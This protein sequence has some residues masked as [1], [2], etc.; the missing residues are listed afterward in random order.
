MKEY[1]GSSI[2]YLHGIFLK[3]M[4]CFLG[5]YIGTLFQVVSCLLPSW[6]CGLICTSILKSR[7]K[8]VERST[9]MTLNGISRDCF[10]LRNEEAPR[11]PT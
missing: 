5:A 4:M 9:Q 2:P 7:K 3:D 1:L 10:I 6:L 11:K 8:T